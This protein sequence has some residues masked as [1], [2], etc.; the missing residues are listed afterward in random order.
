MA[1]SNAGRPL[2]GLCFLLAYFWGW[3]RI[4][5]ALPRVRL[6]ADRRDPALVLAVGLCAAVLAIHLLA[7]VG[8]LYRPVLVLLGVGVVA[9]GL[10]LSATPRRRD[11]P[12]RQAEEWTRW[13]MLAVAVAIALVLLVAGSSVLPDDSWDSL[14][15]HLAVGKL[16]IQQAGITY[17]PWL[18][19]SNFP[20]N[21]ELLFLH[22]LL[23]DGDA[24]PVPLNLLPYVLAAAAVF[25][26]ARLYVGRG[27]ALLGMLVFMTSPEVAAWVNTCNVEIVWAGLATMA[28]WCVLRWRSEAAGV[29][30]PRDAWLYIAGLLAGIAGGTKV[31]ALLSAGAIG[32]IVAGASFDRRHLAA[33]LRP[34]IKYTVV[35]VL[36]ASPCYIQTFVHTGT[37]LWPETLGLFE[38]PDYGRELWARNLAFGRSQWS[39]LPLAPASLALGAWERKH[40]A[41]VALVTVF[42]V[43]ALLRWRHFASVAPL[44]LYVVAHYA[45]WCFATQQE[46]FLIPALPAAIVG[47]MML[48]YGLATTMES[49][50]LCAV[51]WTLTLATAVPAWVMKGERFRLAALPVLSGTVARE[52]VR[53]ANPLYVASRLIDRFTEPEAKILL[54]QEVRGYL[55]DRQYMWGDPLNQGVLSYRDFGSAEELR[56]AL[57]RLDVDYVLVGRKIFPF[58]IERDYAK[59]DWRRMED[60][61]AE[62][63]LVFAT[64]DYV[65]YAVDRPPL[66]PAARVSPLAASALAQDGVTDGSVGVVAGHPLCRGD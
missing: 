57:R 63:R 46:R 10:C 11:S 5:L 18:F 9:V 66:E 2:L 43:A 1:W 62:S 55:L 61:L 12:P 65:L 31:V 41:T 48:T 51:F 42:A 50:R 19:Q 15:Y 20:I 37:P 6:H 52:E 32:A 58:T 27:P 56:Q 3:G 14:A 28:L 39:A 44:F 16:Y 17:L 25:K 22:G 45:F 13:Q 26:L 33:S 49:R 8:L 35:F 23:L 47:L 21:G 54:F 29:A 40:D 59:A 24:L 64:D 38:V 7:A 53:R 34:F 36:A 60:L 4:V 30:E